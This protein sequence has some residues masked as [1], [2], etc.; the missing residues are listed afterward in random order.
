[1]SNV[2]A[3]GVYT[4]LSYADNEEIAATISDEALSQFE[5]YQEL[6]ATEHPTAYNVYADA[7]AAEYALTEAGSTDGAELRDALVG[8]EF[9]TI[10]GNSTIDD[11]GQPSIPGSL[12]KFDGSSGEATVD[13]VAW[14]GQ[15]PP[16]TSIPPE[17]D[18]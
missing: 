9:T 6:D 7:Q 3:L 18:L 2:Y 8:N 4:R 16:I 17:T 14:S 13:T 10:L 11:R 5:S 12:I 15:L 1:M